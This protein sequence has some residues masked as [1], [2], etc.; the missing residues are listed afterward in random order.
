MKRKTY[1][2]VFKNTTQSWSVAAFFKN[3]AISLSLYPHF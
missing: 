1:S 2:R 3:A